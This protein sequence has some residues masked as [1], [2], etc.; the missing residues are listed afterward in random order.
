VILFLGSGQSSPHLLGLSQGVFRIVAGSSGPQVVPPAL[1]AEAG[2][3]RPVVRGSATLQPM[4]LAAFE[5]RVRSLAGA[6][7]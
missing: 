5:S 2:P 6:A 7:R 1:V 4:T 3:V